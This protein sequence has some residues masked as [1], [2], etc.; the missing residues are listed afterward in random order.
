MEVISY[1]FGHIDRNGYEENTV[2]NRM[3][4]SIQIINDSQNI[5]HEV[6]MKMIDY[7][8]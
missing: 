5:L 4:E 2:H 3:K 8:N 6:N 1:K 7:Q